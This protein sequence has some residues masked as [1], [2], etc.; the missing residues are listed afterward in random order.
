MST[1]MGPPSPEQR[2]RSNLV[3]GVLVD[4]L[5]TLLELEPP[6]G[7]LTRQ[8]AERWGVTLSDAEARQAFAAEMD[9][10]RVRHDQGSDDAS[11]ADLRRRCAGVLH[12]SLPA[13]VRE[14]ISAPDLLPA[15]MAS[16][17]FR[18]YP[19]AQDAI[20][21]LRAAGLRLAVVS[22]WDV[23]LV[24]VLR[25]TGLA[26]HFDLVL[27]SAAVGAAKPDP[28]IF[29]RAAADLGLEPRELVHV[30][31]SA[32]LDVGGARAA[33]I[34]PILVVRGASESPA[35]ALGATVVPDLLAAARL[36]A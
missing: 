21:H 3:R 4:S 31:D 12:A 35:A 2:R 9:Y 34:E 13:A 6:A 25:R 27:T 17:R 22:N 30:G 32:E 7:H 19:E 29:R 20:A 28:K 11:L 14:M 18:P 33:G 10:Y 24:E 23:S 36:I 5:G 15:M 16:L 8:V 26:E 1:Q